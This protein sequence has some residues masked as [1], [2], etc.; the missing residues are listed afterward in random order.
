MADD[1]KVY[2]SISEYNKGENKKTELVVLALE[3]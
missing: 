1:S 2:V 3:K